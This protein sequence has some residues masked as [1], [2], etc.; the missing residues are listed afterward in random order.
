MTER[1]LTLNDLLNLS[2]EEISN[3]KIR[4]CTQQESTVWDPIEVFKRDP[5]EVN[6]GWFLNR[7]ERSLLRVGG[8]AICLARLP[9]NN[10][11]WL[12]TTMKTITRDTGI[13]NGGIGWEG[14]EWEKFRPF[15]GRLIVRFHKE[16]AG[17][18]NAP[19]IFDSIEVVQLLP[20]IYED[21]PFPGYDNICL[22]WRELERIIKGNLTDW[23]NA[24]ANQKGVYVIADKQTGLLYVGSAT[25]R[26][27]ML[28]ER[29]AAYVANGHGGN[30]ELMK[31]VSDKGF[32]YVKDNFQY[33][34][35]ENYNSR[36]DDDVILSRE[37]WWKAALDTRGGHGYNRN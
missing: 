27:K 14:E 23:H 36:T 17:V 21:N 20:D 33:T 34:L 28:L 19:E 22:P 1:A 8:Y 6:N 32:D 18:R 25:A 9:Q 11:L 7:K 5:D 16:Q 29:W 2:H 4:F 15:Y 35:L 30:E 13:Y 24:L 31:I 26:N 10:D 37:A 3:T 12:M